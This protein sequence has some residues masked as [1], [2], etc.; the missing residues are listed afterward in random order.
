MFLQFFPVSIVNA[1]LLN[2]LVQNVL[3]FNILTDFTLFLLICLKFYYKTYRTMTFYIKQH[4]NLLWFLTSNVLKITCSIPME[5]FSLIFKVFILFTICFVFCLKNQTFVVTAQKFCMEENYWMKPCKSLTF[6]VH[7]I[8]FAICV[9]FLLLKVLLST[10]LKS[11]NFNVSLFCII[12]AIQNS[13][14]FSL[15]NV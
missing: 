6:L 5:D 1:I 2:Q 12:F 9:T 15:F 13:Y 3:V 11:A 8:L 14:Y 10:V 7:F 4:E